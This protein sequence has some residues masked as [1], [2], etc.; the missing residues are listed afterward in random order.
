MCFGWDKSSEFDQNHTFPGDMKEILLYFSPYVLLNMAAIS[1]CALYAI[2]KKGSL[3][4]TFSAIISVLLFLALMVYT[5]YASPRGYQISY[6]FG[7]ALFVLKNWGFWY[8]FITLP[9]WLF[10]IQKAVAEF[11][12]FA[13]RK[14]F[15]FT[16]LIVFLPWVLY[17]QKVLVFGANVVIV[18]FVII[19]FSKQF[20]TDNA[21]LGMIHQY[22]DRYLDK[23]EK[24]S[25]GLILS[26]LFLLLGWLVPLLSWYIILRG[27]NFPPYYVYYALSGLIFVG[28]GDSMAALGGRRFGKNRWPNTSKTKEGSFLCIWFYTLFYIVV[29]SITQPQKIS[30]KG[31]ELFLAGFVATMVE[32]LTHQFDNFLCPQICFTAIVF[33]NFYFEDYVVNHF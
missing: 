32:A 26:H 25:S 14:Y 30:G 33:M 1:F 16:A 9:L 12:T 22:E 19:E 23:R 6:V 21:I 4:I 2:T 28:I 20:S 5:S 24:N 8:M 15:H 31:I 11:D 10:I 18:L 7:Q 27:A 29:I 17:S 13:L 3:S